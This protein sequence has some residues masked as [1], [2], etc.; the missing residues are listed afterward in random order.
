MSGAE[1]LC[2]VNVGWSFTPNKHSPDIELTFLLFLACRGPLL[3]V[4]QSHT[5]RKSWVSMRIMKINTLK[6]LKRYWFIYKTSGGTNAK[7]NVATVWHVHPITHKTGQHPSGSTNVMWCCVKC[8]DRLIFSSDNTQNWPTSIWFNKC[9]VV[10]CEMPGP[11]DRIIKTEY[12]KSHTN[13]HTFMFCQDWHELL[14]RL[15]S[16]SKLINIIEQNSITWEP[17]MIFTCSNK[18]CIKNKVYNPLQRSVTVVRLFLNIYMFG[19]NLSVGLNFLFL[20]FN[21]IKHY[22]NQKQGRQNLNQW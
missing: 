7:Q 15:T 8:R 5:G 19:S 21:F 6:S 14:Q 17:R 16:F 13:S 18:F 22:H 20:C 11:F 10:L 12:R 4:W 1:F 9:Y 2:W 3:F